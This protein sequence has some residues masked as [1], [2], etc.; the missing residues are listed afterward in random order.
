MLA[1]WAILSLVCLASMSLISFYFLCFKLFSLN[2]LCLLPFNLRPL[3][4]NGCLV[5]GIVIFIK[6]LLSLLN[7]LVTGKNTPMVTDL[8][9]KP[10]K[11]S[12]KKIQKPTLL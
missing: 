12:P 5:L 6:P 4:L 9:E 7:D 1:S 11:H 10:I 8:K 3:A 2:L